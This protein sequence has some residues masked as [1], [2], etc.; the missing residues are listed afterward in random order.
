MK[1]IIYGDYRTAKSTPLVS[2]LEAEN[3]KIGYIFFG[4][5]CYEHDIKDTIAEVKQHADK[6]D[7]FVL[8]GTYDDY[9]IK[10]CENIQKRFEDEGIENFIILSGNGYHYALHNDKNFYYPLWWIQTQ[11]TAVDFEGNIFQPKKYIFSSLNGIARLHRVLLAK[12]M[13]KK[14]Y[15]DRCCLTFNHNGAPDR[16]SSLWSQTDNW[17]LDIEFYGPSGR[18][19]LNSAKEFLPYYHNEINDYHEL[20]H[21]N[22]NAAYSDTYVNII[23]ETSVCLPFF[24]EKTFKALAS[25]QFFISINGPGSIELLKSFGFDTFDDIIDHSRY[26]NIANPYKKIK[27]ISE[28]LDELVQLDW[29]NLWALTNNRRRKNVEHFFSDAYK[30]ITKP[31]EQRIKSL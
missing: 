14:S 18:E 13:L 24:T 23:T 21:A 7:L 26:N 8:D 10:F 31:F 5:L 19:L 15:L 22:L 20:D 2:Y 9:S 28:L 30:E 11:V 27:A 4:H 16:Y 6:I 3:K 29:P 1:R 17:W 12:H 25:G